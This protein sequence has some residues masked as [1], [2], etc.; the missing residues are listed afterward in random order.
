[1]RAAFALRIP[2]RAVRRP[3]TLGLRHA[4]AAGGKGAVVG[5]ERSRLSPSQNL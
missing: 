5:A 4:A 2:M 3:A 1:M